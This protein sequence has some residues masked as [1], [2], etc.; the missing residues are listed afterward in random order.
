MSSLIEWNP[1]RDLEKIRSD[2]DDLMERF[3]RKSPWPAEFEKAVVRPRLESFVEEGKLTIRADLPGIDPKN[4]EVTI[5]DNELNVRAKR[6]EESET[7]KRNFLKREVRYGSYEYSTDLPK[8]L[9]AEDLKASYKDGVLEL[10][11]AMPKEMLPKQVKV[12]VEGAEPKKI[13]AKEK[14][15][16]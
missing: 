5:Y 2:F 16:A 4:I 15:A 3:W 10:T 13:E 11:A 6:Q 8:G 1:V 7:K 9:K 14:S 12:Q